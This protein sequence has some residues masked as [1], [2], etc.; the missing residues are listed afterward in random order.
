MIIDAKQ[1]N[2][3]MRV[4]FVPPENKTVT[5]SMINKNPETM[6]IKYAIDFLKNVVFSDMIVARAE[7]NIYIKG[8]AKAFRNARKHWMNPALI[9]QRREIFRNTARWSNQ[10]EPF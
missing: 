3:I 9:P 2:Y 1:V 4:A 7:L 6:R 8:F 10:I 5:G